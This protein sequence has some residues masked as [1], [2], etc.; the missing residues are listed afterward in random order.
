MDKP[1]WQIWYGG[2]PTETVDLI[3][4]EC[5]KYPA[6]ESFIGSNS[7]NSRTDDSYRRSEISWINGRSPTSTFIAH[8]LIYRAHEANR[9]AWGFNITNTVSDIQYTKYH[10]KD[11]GFYSWHIDTFFLSNETAY[12]RKLSVVIQLSD[13]NEY[14]GGNFKFD[15]TLPAPDPQLLRQK[16]TVIV[17]PSFLSHMVEPVTSGERKSLVSWIEGPK[18]R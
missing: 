17:F 7:D 12:D 2:I 13:S 15:S 5:E 6:S 16:G 10:A 9:R 8:E 14:E 1:A 3:V 11:N 4:E 18:F